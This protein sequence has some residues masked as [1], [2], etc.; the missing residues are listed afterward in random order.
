M[1]VTVTLHVFSGRP[2]PSWELSTAQARE[3]TKRLASLSK[4]TLM[5]PPGI[6][7]GLGYRGFSIESNREPHLDEHMLIHSS[8]VDLQRFTA[9]LVD[10]TGIEQWLLG[11]GGAALDPDVSKH[12]EDA[13]KGKASHQTLVPSPLTAAPSGPPPY[14]PGKWNNDPSV[15]R[16]NNCYN[17]AND[18]ITNSFAQPG[19]ASGHPA[20]KIDC[21]DET[22]AAVSD[23]L[24]SVPNATATGLPGWFVALVIWP[25][26]DFHWYR[27]DA[28]GKWSHKP[29]QTPARNVDN[30]GHVIADP[31]TCDRGPYT[32]FC[33]YLNST[34]GEC[35]IL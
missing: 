15:L 2:D 25:G 16:R 20:A 18:T 5:K 14:N 11:T 10:E 29:G 24:R 26:M 12:V 9:N 7:H 35:R 21:A 30:A 4:Q 28:N 34:P 23:G 33:G 6:T 27:K 32:S 1:S 3:L 13:I 19:R 8:I 17:Y 31:A 22:A